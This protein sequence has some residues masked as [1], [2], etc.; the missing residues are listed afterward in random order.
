MAKVFKYILSLLL[1]RIIAKLIFPAIIAVIAYKW[2]KY[3]ANYKNAV[4]K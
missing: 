3:Y 1:L 4:T 2:Q